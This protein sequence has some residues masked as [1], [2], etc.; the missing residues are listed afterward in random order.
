MPCSLGTCIYE[1]CMHPWEAVA[2]SHRTL[3]CGGDRWVQQRSLRVCKSNSSAR[4]SSKIW[5]SQQFRNKFWYSA[6]KLRTHQFSVIIMSYVGQLK[7]SRAL[8][9]V[10]CISLPG[11][12]IHLGCSALAGHPIPLIWQL[13]QYRDRVVEQNLKWPADFYGKCR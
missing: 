2:N 9:E 5:N 3:Q 10:Y 13:T 8:V 12:P 11:E 6:S 7:F 4:G 1:N